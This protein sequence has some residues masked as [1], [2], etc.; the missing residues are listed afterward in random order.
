MRYFIDIGN[1][2]IKFTTAPH[3]TDR[4]F[5]TPDFDIHATTHDKLPPLLQCL[6]S[7]KKQ[8]KPQ[9]LLI[10][11]GRS[12]QAQASLSSIENVAKQHHIET[13]RAEVKPQ[14][15]AVNYADSSQFGIDRFLN[16]LAAR[17]H[18]HNYFCVVSCG[19]A[20][21]LD[22]YTQQHI[23]GMIL[24]GL[25]AS[26]QLLM[27]KTGLQSIGKPTK[28]LGNDTAS[29]IGVGL[30]FG[31]QNL[32]KESIARIE[33]NV[34]HSFLVVFTGGDAE[35]LCTRKKVIPQLLFQG[36]AIYEQKIINAN[37]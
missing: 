17:E 19:T 10:A 36:M 5:R 16:L 33:K 11:A 1:T 2:R 7:D 15:L 28:L 31:Y 13:I 6:S 4:Q 37:R 21:T 12:P 20:I 18:L 23:G 32:I 26:K 27:E 22:F 3:R 35:V 24:P 14:L 34:N 30:Y 25:G 29:S 9:R 8:N